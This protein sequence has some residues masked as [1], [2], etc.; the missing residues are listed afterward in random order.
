MYENVIPLFRCKK[1]NLKI[2]P[3]QTFD[4]FAKTTTQTPT[5][6]PRLRGRNKRTVD[7]D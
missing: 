2:L 7:F 5:P 3:L 1:K 4:H 6:P